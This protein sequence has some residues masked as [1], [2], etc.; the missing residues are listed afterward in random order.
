MGVGG[1]PRVV[2]MNHP[3]L[4]PRAGGV[5]L[6]LVMTSDTL[7]GGAERIERHTPRAVNQAI[8]DHLDARLEY[9]AAHPQQIGERL[10]QL[11]QEWDIERAL[12]A[13]SA[14]MTLGGIAL[15]YTRS[16]RW[17]LL[18]VVVQSFFIQHAVQGWCPPLP[19]LRSLGLRTVLEIEQER[20]ALLELRESVHAPGGGAGRSQGGA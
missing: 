7:I 1:L 17:L 13:F 15:A 11:Q 6:Q 2:A 3:A 4:I 10:E 16:P 18:P 14:M 20:R 19:L 5:P 9:Y 12:E 8:G